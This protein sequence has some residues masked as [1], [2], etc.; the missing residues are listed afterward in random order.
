MD[1]FAP[2][3]PF[4]VYANRP[5]LGVRGEATGCPLSDGRPGAVYRGV[6]REQTRSL[7]VALPEARV[8]SYVPMP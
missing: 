7:P 8:P 2:M 6:P 4:T 3:I 5:A 1:I